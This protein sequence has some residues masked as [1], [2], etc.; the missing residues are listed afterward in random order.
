MNNRGQNFTNWGKNAGYGNYNQ[1]NRG[2]Q[3]FKT[4]GFKKANTKNGKLLFNGWKKV[5]R[6]LLKFTVYEY[7]K[8]KKNTNTNGKCYYNCLVSMTEKYNETIIGNIN[9]YHDGKDYTG[10]C[11][12]AGLYF[13]TKGFG[14]TKSGKSV[15]GSITNLSAMRG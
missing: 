6:D 15:K 7:H 2:V 14:Q 10:Q 5:G 9:L 8:T 1:G 13:S 3:S 12:K 4:S 11:D